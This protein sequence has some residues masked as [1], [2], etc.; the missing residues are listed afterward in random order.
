M[1]R[2]SGTRT[3]LM[4]RPCENLDGR[5]DGRRFLLHSLAARLATQVMLDLSMD[6][7]TSDEWVDGFSL[8]AKD[9]SFDSMDTDYEDDMPALQGR[10]SSS[11][12]EGST[13][14]EESDG[15][16]GRGEGSRSG[17]ERAQDEYEG[18]G[19]GRER[20]MEWDDWEEVGRDSRDSGRRDWDDDG[21][22]WVAL[23]EE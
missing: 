15:A 10:R 9:M 19:R 8:P 11:P 1:E 4:D 17:G 22:G 12:A 21:Q 2:R 14:D 16:Y 5:R 20:D 6:F 18:L 3:R 13:E 7:T 23:G